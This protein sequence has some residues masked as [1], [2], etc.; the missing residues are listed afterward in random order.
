CARPRAGPPPR[1]RGWRARGEAGARRATRMGVPPPPAR[2]R[3][4]RQARRDGRARRETRRPL[5]L[6]PEAPVV[7]AARDVELACSRAD[8][9][10]VRAVELAAQGWTAEP[11]RAGLAGPRDPPDRPGPRRGA[12]AHA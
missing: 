11:A 4:R 1:R 2:E 9:G 7:L 8:L 12:D 5:L 10:S 6:G 3:A